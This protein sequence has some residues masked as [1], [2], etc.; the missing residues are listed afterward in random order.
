MTFI[1]SIAEIDEDFVVPFELGSKYEAF[2]FKEADATPSGSAQTPLSP[3]RLENLLFQIGNRLRR[4]LRK[5]HHE[6]KGP[7]LLGKRP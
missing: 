5:G 1:S 2:G 3:K 7:R 4:G 6:D